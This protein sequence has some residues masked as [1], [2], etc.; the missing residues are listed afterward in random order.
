MN[1][2]ISINAKRET[3]ETKEL[4]PIYAPIH[5]KEYEG[6][7]IK[8]VHSDENDCNCF[9]VLESAKGKK[10]TLHISDCAFDGYALKIDE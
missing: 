7:K 4:S 9:I 3:Q 5:L 1:K 6:Y 2:V 8:E 10:V